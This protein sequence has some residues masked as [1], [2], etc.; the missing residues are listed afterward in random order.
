MSNLQFLRRW[1]RLGSALGLLL[2]LWSCAA[3]PEKP[4]RPMVYDFGPGA[5]TLSLSPAESNNLPTITLGEIEAPAA[6]DSS[7]MLYRLM[8]GNPTQLQPYALARWSMPPAQLLRQRLREILEVQRKV[9]NPSPGTTGLYMQLELEEFVQLFE[10]AERSSGS[11]R[12]RATLKRIN[13]GTEQVLAQR[14]LVM[15]QPAPSP[16]AAGGVR[17]LASASEALAKELTQWL[18]RQP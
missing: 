12:L 8:Y 16:D 18:G 7:A 5:L 6:L 11:I 4:S 2:L 15:L 3:L 17:A 1:V 9:L 10:S 14:R 13:G